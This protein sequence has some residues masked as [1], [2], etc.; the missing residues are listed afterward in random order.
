[1]LK[2]IKK[3]LRESQIYVKIESVSKS[4]MS[5]K[6][7]FF[8]VYNN[9]LVE[10]TSYLHH[11]ESKEDPKDLENCDYVDCVTLRGCGLDVIAYYLYNIMLVID[12]KK[13]RCSSLMYKFI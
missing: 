13:A 4:R 2:I 5:R 8:I 6:A 10:I 7:R 9:S 12:K 1:M 11:I 3:R